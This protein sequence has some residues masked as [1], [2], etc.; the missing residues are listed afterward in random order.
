VIKVIPF[1]LNGINGYVDAALLGSVRLRRSRAAQSFNPA[2]NAQTG[3]FPRSTGR[4][5]RCR[6][7]ATIRHG[8]DRCGAGV[9]HQCCGLSNNVTPI[10]LPASA[11]NISGGDLESIC[12]TEVAYVAAKQ[13]FG[14]A[15]TVTVKFVAAD[16]STTPPG[17]YAMTLP[18]GAP[19][20]GQ[21]S[22]TLPI[23]LAAQAAVAGKYTIEASAT[24]YTSQ[25]VSKDLSAADATQS[26][27]LVP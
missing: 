4:K 18:I 17:A 2:P 3:E 25:S 19:L 22:A 5:L 14:A 11:H 9:A 21:Y 8:S 12:S 20:L 23:A 15:P 1:V 6:S 7:T 16:D 27:T 10:T 24:G 26:F 13:T